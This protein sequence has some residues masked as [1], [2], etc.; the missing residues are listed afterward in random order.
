M[1]IN[2]NKLKLSEIGLIFLVWLVSVVVSSQV[3]IFN[4]PMFGFEGLT[5]HTLVSMRGFEEWGFW[6]LLGAS[7]LFPK[8]YE[9]FGVDLTTL[10]KPEIY[11]S[12]PSL[13]LVLP[14]IVFKLLNLLPLGVSLSPQYLQVYN[15]IFNRLLCAMVVYYLYLEI[16]KILTQDVLTD[17]KKRLIA[18]L[19][20]VGWIF[21]PPVLFWTQNVYFTDQIVLLPVYAIFFISLKC[22]FNFNQLPNYYKILLC[23][24]SILAC[25]FD[26][27]GWVGIASILF[28]KFIDDL[29]S[30]KAN[31]FL[32]KAFLKQYLNSVK[33]ILFGVI[34]SGFTFI[35]QL[36]YYKDGI[37]QFLS[38]FFS[39]TI[40]MSTDTGVSLTL[41]TMLRGI[42]MHWSSYFPRIIQPLLENADSLLP[43]VALIIGFTL[44][45]FCLYYLYKK[46]RY[47]RFV[48]YAYI[49]VFL[50]PLIQLFILKQHSFI[51]YFSAFKM[52]L[53]ITFSLLV[54]PMVTLSQI[55]Q[56]A[57]SN[58]S[59]SS[60]SINTIL[61]VFVAVLGI[62]IVISSVGELKKFASVG[63]AST[64][65][66]QDIGFLLSRNVAPTELPITGVPNLVVSSYPPQVIWYGKRYLY[67]YEQLKEL[68]L[69]ANSQH[70]K[71]MKP[72]F[73]T[74]KDTSSTAGFSLI[75]QGK[76]TDLAEKVESREIVACRAVELNRLLASS[77]FPQ[78]KNPPTSYILPTWTGDLAQATLGLIP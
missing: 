36:L 15:L 10:T 37:R 63:G 47:S 30:N 74:Y 3:F 61:S 6:K 14:Y 45:L 11:L 19:G 26:W 52:G 54:L 12:Y 5:A 17:Y 20:L 43:F 42:A 39:R 28:L 71:S 50:V 21:T 9:F 65:R 2:F 18:L 62:V 77:S 44:F 70:L 24:T 59:F 40:A 33:F 56:S 58:T 78:V 49:L 29:L 75:C 68:R 4:R 23:I 27:Y 76:W 35:V 72:V 55:F 22:R 73:L 8:S 31:P 66:A 38:I 53:P 46:S 13:W 1:P 7:T 69:R 60:R 67:S 48:V 25:G 32:S 57:R 51:H 16:I 34:V 64:D 41:L